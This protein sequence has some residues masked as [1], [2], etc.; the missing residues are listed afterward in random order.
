MVF[1]EGKKGISISASYQSNCQYL[2]DVIREGD[3]HFSSQKTNGLRCYFCGNSV[4]STG[5]VLV[6][7]V[8]NGFG[9]NIGIERFVLGYDCY[10]RTK[11]GELLKCLALLPF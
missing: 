11:K 9:E 8:K 3:L 10:D 7:D 5:L 6:R 2:F 4:P 1:E